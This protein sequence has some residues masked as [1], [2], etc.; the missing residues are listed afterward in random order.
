MV[1]FMYRI[2]SL[3]TSFFHESKCVIVGTWNM[4]NCKVPE[5]INDFLLPAGEKFLQEI[6]VVGVQE[7]TPEQYVFYLFF[8]IKISNSVKINP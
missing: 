2:Y 7:S 4:Q 3:W 5:N 6:Y 8:W 1:I